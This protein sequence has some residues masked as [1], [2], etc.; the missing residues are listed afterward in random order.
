[1][2][3]IPATKVEIHTDGDRRRSVRVHRHHGLRPAGSPRHDACPRC[4]QDDDAGTGDCEVEKLGPVLTGRAGF[5][6][7]PTARRPARSSGSRRQGRYLPRLAPSPRLPGQRA[8][9]SGCASWASSSPPADSV[10]DLV[11]THER[12]SRLSSRRALHTVHD[13][14]HHLLEGG[15]DARRPRPHTIPHS[16][17]K[18]DL[19][20]GGVTLHKG[21]EGKTGSQL[22]EDEDGL[23]VNVVVR[24]G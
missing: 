17:A 10:V 19:I 9:G 1:M 16:G 8:S 21:I 13:R 14:W 2:A 5:T 15:L 18:C 12:R 11:G 6:I 3:W 22:F 4:A 7:E 20:V 23:E 24:L